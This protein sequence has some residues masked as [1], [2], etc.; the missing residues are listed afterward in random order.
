M[1]KEEIF[2]LIQELNEKQVETICIEAKAASYGKPEK[3]YDTISSFSNTMGGNN[4]IWSWRKENK[5]AMEVRNETIVKLLE[6]LGGIIENR[7]TGISTMQ[8]KM[9]ESNLPNPIF[10]NER[11]DFVV[12]FYNGEYPELYPE[13][14]KQDKKIQDKKIQDK[15][16]HKF[17]TILEICKEPKSINE[18]MQ[19][20]KYKSSPTLKRDYIKP[21]VES[22]RLKM[23]IPDKPT[24]RNQKL[25]L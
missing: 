24:S 13:E 14:L 10:T 17:N 2:K 7:H 5:K 1:N 19:E 3:Y 9:K 15:K 22:G 20:L 12:T 6:N 25:L 11:E 4:I 18:I 21:L 8:D 16:A 23:T